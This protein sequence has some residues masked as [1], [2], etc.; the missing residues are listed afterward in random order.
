MPL[1]MRLPKRGFN[2]LNPTKNQ[3]INLSDIEKALTEGRLKKS[4]KITCET[5]IGAGLIRGNSQNPVRLLAK[6]TLKSKCDIEVDS[7][8]ATAIEA[9]KKAGGSL[10]LLQ[11]SK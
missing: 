5:L 4:E 7:A 2:P 6:G 3:V 9:V 1:H 8:S 11:Q 10:S